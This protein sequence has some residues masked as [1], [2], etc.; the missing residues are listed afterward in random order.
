MRIQLAT[1]NRRIGEPEWRRVT[2]AQNKQRL[3]AASRKECRINRTWWVAP[4]FLLRIG[5]GHPVMEHSDPAPQYP[6]TLLGRIPGYT[7]ARAPGCLRAAEDIVLHLHF[8]VS[9]LVRQR[10]SLPQDKVA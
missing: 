10:T 7:H 1:R 5:G 4:H 6:I 9:H 8:S 2:V 3:D